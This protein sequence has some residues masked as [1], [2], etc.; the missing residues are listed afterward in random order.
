MEPITLYGGE[1]DIPFIYY[2]AENKKT[3][4]T[5]IVLP[6]GGYTGLADHEGKGY[7]EF[8]NAFGID[9]FVLYYRVAPNYFPKP[10]L[11]ARRA[12][13]YVRANAERYGINPNK[14]AIMGSSAGGHLAAMTS[15]YRAEIPEEAGD[16]LLAV[17][18]LPNASVLCYPVIA[19]SDLAV[20]HVGSCFNHL[21]PSGLRL[22]KDVDPVL[23]IDEK[24]PPAFLWHTS[25]DAVVNV[26]NSLRYGETLRRHGVP[27]EMHVFPHGVHG[28]GYTEKTP[29]NIRV[30]ADLLYTWFE[31]IG[32][33][34]KQ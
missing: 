13:R 18:P 32:F 23:L 9:A 14:I 8:L 21:G 10:L 28:L 17:S 33:I 16:E 11:D 29:E 19:L 2:P 4:M 22:A 25:D 7:A 24:T 26:I 6:G 20:T 27:F 5:V 15:N 3:D 1:P 31:E 12:V 30:W 34:D